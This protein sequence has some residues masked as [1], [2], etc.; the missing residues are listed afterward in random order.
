MRDVYLGI[1]AQP[2]QLFGKLDGV[3]VLGGDGQVPLAVGEGRFQDEMAQVRNAIDGAPEFLGGQRVARIDE[4]A[5]RCP[6]VKAH[7]R[8]GVVGGD[9]SDGAVADLHGTAHLKRAVDHPRPLEV[10]D[11]GE[12]RPDDPVEDVV[13]QCLDGLGQG[14]DD[15]GTLPA[16]AHG[17]EH[18]RQC[19]DVV[20]VGVGQKDVV[21]AAH[22]LD[23][24]VLDA[25]AGID[26]DVVVDE[27][28]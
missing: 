13:L 25:G 12:I 23:R 20:K 26:Q 19:A 7:G 6:D 8:H 4:A 18:Q 9:G 22:V 24:Q 3:Q 10:R 11:L 15:D 16:A 5:G 27:E 21:D 28:G 2:G 14:M 17:V 1:D